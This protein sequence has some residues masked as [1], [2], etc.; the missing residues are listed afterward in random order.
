[1][2]S[3]YFILFV[4]TFEIITHRFLFPTKKKRK[5]I[6]SCVLHEQEFVSRKSRDNCQLE[7]YE[8]YLEKQ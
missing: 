5:T 1:M 8:Q 7:F 2:E 4:H 3:E 6:V